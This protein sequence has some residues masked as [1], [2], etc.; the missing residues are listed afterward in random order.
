MLCI[1][2]IFRPVPRSRET[3]RTREL[4]HSKD[5]SQVGKVRPREIDQEKGSFMTFRQC[6]RFKVKKM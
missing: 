5:G 2:M 4:Q 1:K 3:G 6:M